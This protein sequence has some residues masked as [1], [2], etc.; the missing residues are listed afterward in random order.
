ME[1]IDLPETD[2]FV[3]LQKFNRQWQLL[4]EATRQINSVLELPEVMRKLVTSAM[5]LTEAEEGTAGILINGKMVF[6]EYNQHGNIFPIDYCFEEGSG[7]PG[8]VMATRKPYISNKAETDEH[9][10]PQIQKTL[11]FYNLADTPIL[12]NKGEVIGCFEL[13]NKPTGFDEHDV[14]LLQNLAASTAVAIENSRMI[15]E[16]KR[17]EKVLSETE[18]LYRTTFYSIGD[19]VITTDDKGFIQRVNPVAEKLTGW[20]EAD[21]QGKMLEEVFRIINEETREIVESPAQKVLNLGLIVGLANHTLL[22]SKDGKEIPIADSGAPIKDEDGKVAGVVL[23]FRDQ[24]EERKSQRLL[25]ESEAKYRELIESTDAIAWEYNIVQDKWTY[26]APQVTDK[27]G[28]LPEEWTDMN[29]WKQNIHPDDR[30]WANNFCLTATAKGESHTLEYRFM[31][32]DG[33]YIW[34]RDVIAVEN[35]DNKPIKLRG[36]MLDIS[37]LK[38]TELLLREKEY[39]LSESQRVGKI[40]SYDFDIANNYWKSSEILDEIFG[41]TKENLHTLES[42]NAFIY[43]TQR[44]EMLDYFLNTVIKEREPFEKEY[45]IIREND[46]SQHWVLGNGELNYNESG[47]PVRM[48]GTIQDITERKIAEQQLQESEERFRKAVLQAPIPIMVHDED[49]TVINVNEGWT[50]YSGYSACEIPTLKEWTLK[51]YGEKAKEVEDYISGL[52]DEEKTIFSGEFEII[53]K[54]GEKRI[55]NFF[56]TPLGKLSSGKKSCLVLLQM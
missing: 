26:V 8:W 50:H 46:G 35:Q 33:N 19:A 3:Q 40:G 39:F 12:N 24:T 51:A 15:E 22:L 53:S 18:T 4:T 32:K 31:G 52:F 10:I 49:G 21:A 54:S 37:E 29:F 45:K 14:M 23:V 11:G 9:V 42:W 25:E 28:W 48:F 20:K 36:I 27:L 55:W 5:G 1:K 16:R 43:P 34:L 30:V 56:T 38:N 47:E 17:F 2:A 44:Q 41:I 7:V 6:T 13:H